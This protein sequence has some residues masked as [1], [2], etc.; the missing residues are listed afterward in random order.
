MAWPWSTLEDRMLLP[1]TLLAVFTRLFPIWALLF[2]SACS[3]ATLPS[4]TP[5][6][7]VLIPTKT[8]EPFSNSDRQA[9]SQWCSDYHELQETIAVTDDRY[10]S[11]VKEVDRITTELNA[12]L[13]EGLAYPEPLP[14]PK[15]WGQTARDL[16]DEFE[17]ALDSAYN[18]P[19]RPPDLRPIN[20]LVIQYVE[21]MS[22]TS[23]QLSWYYDN[24]DNQY[25]DAANEALRTA[26]RSKTEMNDLVDDLF[27]LY[28]VMP[29]CT[30][31]P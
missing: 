25:Y 15:L 11:F 18:L 21:M 19:R 20:D 8:P 13:A 24:G 17:Q 16:S 23:S 4:P 28:R 14:D 30:L 22:E 1:R 12:A 26:N 5:P 6:P 27:R 9:V 7:P 31:F 10:N 3:P 29:A 2:A